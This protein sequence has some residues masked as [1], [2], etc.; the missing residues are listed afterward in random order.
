MLAYYIKAFD[1][2]NGNAGSLALQTVVTQTDPITGYLP[3]VGEAFN[4]T[5]YPDL[6]KVVG[7]AYTTVTD[8]TTFN[9]QNIA[10]QS[11]EP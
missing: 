5:D 10:I 3:C 6:F 11:M 7:M 9:V 4:V 8:G 1:D 2:S